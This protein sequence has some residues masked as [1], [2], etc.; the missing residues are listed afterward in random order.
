R[1]LIN[2]CKIHLNLH[3]LYC[4]ITEDNHASLKLFENHGFH[5]IGLKKDWNYVH[6]SYKNEYLLQRI[7]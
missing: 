4:N 5:I 3:Q 7:N 6:G 2:Y 1:L